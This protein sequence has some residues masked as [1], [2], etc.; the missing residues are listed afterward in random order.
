[1]S[2]LISR[3]RRNGILAGDEQAVTAAP[4][5]DQGAGRADGAGAAVAAQATG[6]HGGPHDRTG[7]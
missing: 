5:Q 6:W 3:L 1:M 2:A 7:P 4:A